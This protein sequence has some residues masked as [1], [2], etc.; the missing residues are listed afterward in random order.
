MCAFEKEIQHVAH[1][2]VV[3]VASAVNVTSESVVKV[4]VTIK[5]DENM[6]P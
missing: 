5:T 2:P 6:I 4:I 3:V 1:S